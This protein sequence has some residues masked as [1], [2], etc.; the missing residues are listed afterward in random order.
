[1]L[2]FTVITVCLNAGQGLLDTISRTLAQKYDDFEILVKDG[3]SKDGSVEKL[4]EDPRI[5]LVQRKDTGI[6][7]AMNQAVEEARGEYLIFMNCGDWFYSD[8]V[9]AYIAGQIE[10]EKA[11]LY[12]GRCFYRTTGEVHD[13][14][15]TISRLTC[16]RT[17][18]CHQAMVIRSDVLR[19]HPYDLSYRII[20]D[21]ELLWNLVLG[22]GVRPQY[23][24]TVIASYQG[25]G[26][27]ARPE[28]IARN[29]ADQKRLKDTYY[30]RTEQ[31]KYDLMM[32]LSLQEFRKAWSKHPKYGKYYHG[33]IRWLY[34][35]KKK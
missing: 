21:R 23:L 1:M 35:L 18:I 14:P 26:E 4:P 24:D 15:R 32:A 34:S 8:D 22:Q 20:A 19:E 27:S 31:L 10:K 13:Y 12:Y 25:G 7:D 5:R 17:M 9:L 29:K 28:H 11:P 16:Y 2:K 3:F 33:L 30:P 6:Y